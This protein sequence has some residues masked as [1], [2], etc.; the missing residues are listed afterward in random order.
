MSGLPPDAID[1]AV[2]A[3]LAQHGLKFTED[4]VWPIVW[5]ALTDAA[6]LIAAAER[7][8][9]LAMISQLPDVLFTRADLRALLA[10]APEVKA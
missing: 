6:P 9:I 10:A 2:Q 5:I 4:E 8:R 7:E 3:V 1:T